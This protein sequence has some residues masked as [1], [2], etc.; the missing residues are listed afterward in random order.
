MT[1]SDHLAA[2]YTAL[3]LLLA[4]NTGQPDH[5]SIATQLLN[6][7]ESDPTEVL[8]TVLMYT[9]RI[10]PLPEASRPRILAEMD[11][12]TASM[13]FSDELTEWRTR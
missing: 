1:E 12:L 7:P 3:W 9:R 2:R 13:V 4:T 10:D 5:R 6:D 11:N 8:W